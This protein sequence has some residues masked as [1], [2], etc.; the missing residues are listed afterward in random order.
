MNNQHAIRIESL[1]KK[2]ML[3]HHQQ[4]EKYHALRDTFGNSFRNILHWMRRKTKPNKPEEFWALRDVNLNITEGEVVG[5]IG[6][7]GAGKSTLLKIL[8]RITEPS[9]GRVTLNGRIASLLEVGTGFHPELTGRDNIYLNGSILGMSRKE[10]RNK[11]AEIV[12][13]AEIEKFL[14]TPVKRYSSGMYI[15]LA[16]AVA[17]H[18]EPEILIV[19]EVLAVGDAQFQKKCLGKM[20]EVARTGRTVL[21]VSHQ[22]ANIIQLCNRCVLLD[23]GKILADGNTREI[24]EQYMSANRENQNYERDIT[25]KPHGSY[26]QSA[27]ILEPENRMLEFGEI[28]HVQVVC[29]SDV[30]VIVAIEFIIRDESMH[31]IIFLPSGLRFGTEFE[32][33]PDTPITIRCTIG[34]LP[35]AVGKYAIDILLARSGRAVDDRQENALHFQITY[36]DPCG[37]HSQFTQQ[38][39]QGC[40]HIPATFTQVK[41]Q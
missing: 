30:T 22:M 23:N 41:D 39:R 20:N 9:T 1:G 15:R 12:A 24:V 38:Q 11:F 29:H 16:F 17:A 19:D 34:P 21:F 32:L 27:S 5:I 37:T 28:L 31:P 4:R 36:A 13:F 8:S 18:L 25:R 3:H 33:L 14:D 2:Y 10:I 40:V 6:R 35:L 26:I 7:N